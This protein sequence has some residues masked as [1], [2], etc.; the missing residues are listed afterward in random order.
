MLLIQ[1]L[2]NGVLLGGLYACMAIGFSVIWG[3]MNL[4]NIAHGSMI[5]LGAYIT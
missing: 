2:I 1:V 3:V 5:I 4:I